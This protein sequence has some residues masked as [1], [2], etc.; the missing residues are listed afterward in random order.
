MNK[1]SGKIIAALILSVFVM[2]L[3]YLYSVEVTQA[4]SPNKLTIDNQ[5]EKDLYIVVKRD[6]N[7]W[8]DFSTKPPTWGSTSI[9][10]KNIHKTTGSRDSISLIDTDTHSANVYVCT[11]KPS[12]IPS[13][14]SQ[15]I[16][17]FFEY[18]TGNTWDISAVDAVG[19][20]MC[21]EF[22]TRKSGYRNVPREFIMEKFSNLPAPFNADGAIVRDDNDKILRALA[23]KH[24]LSSDTD[25]LDSAMKVGFPKFVKNSKGTTITSG[26]YTYSDFSW[27]SSNKTLSAH[28]GTD[29]IRIGGGSGKNAFS[30]INVISTAMTERNDSSGRLTALIETAANRGVLNDPALWGQNDKTFGGFT[31][32]PW[33]YYQNNGRTANA[34]QYNRYSKTV[35]QWS[36]NGMNYGLDHDD[37]YN[38]SSSITVPPGEPVILHIWKFT[39]S[40]N[41]EPITWLAHKHYLSLGISQKLIN[42]LGYVYVNKKQYTIVDVINNIPCVGLPKTTDI[43]FSNHPGKKLNV[44]LVSR[45]VLNPQDWVNGSGVIIDDNYHIAF[46]ANFAPIS[47]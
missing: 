17:D 42:K 45:T 19:I 8:L 39:G 41:D 36:V 10:E 27:D 13:L 37:L 28:C 46:P 22:K 47:Q 9:A 23:P 2:P 32:F 35:H 29:T 11:F 1:S 15:Q 7:K 18:N 21:L 34:D 4:K 26:P 40:S 24:Y 12:G 38:R 5:S 30:S 44:D 31:G 14:S 16:W 6:D 25:C 43:Q 3:T 20:P 33:N